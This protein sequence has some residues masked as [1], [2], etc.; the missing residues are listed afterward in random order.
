MSIQGHFEFGRCTIGHQGGIDFNCDGHV[1]KFERMET[2]DLRMREKLL[3]MARHPFRA[4][5]ERFNHHGR[6]QRMHGAEFRHHG[7]GHRPGMPIPLVPQGSVWGNGF[8]GPKGPG[9]RFC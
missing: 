4:L 6:A 8:A 5:A 2:R 3:N 9:H 7:G 1:S